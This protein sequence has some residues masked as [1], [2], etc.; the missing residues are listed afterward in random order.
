[1]DLATNSSVKVTLTQITIHIKG[2]ILQVVCW[3]SGNQSR[4][5]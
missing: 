5:I 3:I 1:M 4:N 2:T